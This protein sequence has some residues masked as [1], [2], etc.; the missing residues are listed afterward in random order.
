MSFCL[1]KLVKNNEHDENIFLNFLIEIQF[2]SENKLSKVV[3]PVYKA[4]VGVLL[5]N[6]FTK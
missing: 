4:T 1:L 3:S 2:C 5:R 6:T